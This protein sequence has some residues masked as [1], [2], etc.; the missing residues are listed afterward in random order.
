MYKTL[1][2]HVLSEREHELRLMYKTLNTHVLSE[3]GTHE[4]RLMHK[5]H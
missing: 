2:T 3:R 5:K 4:L 1:N